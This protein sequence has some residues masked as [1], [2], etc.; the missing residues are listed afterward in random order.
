MCDN[1]T[2]ISNINNMGSIKCDSCNQ[3]AYNIWDNCITEELQISAAHIPE[4][5]NM[6]VNTSQKMKFSIKDFFSKCYQIR[7]KLQI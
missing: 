1:M 2:V 6:E 5:S 4:A 3:I 7:S